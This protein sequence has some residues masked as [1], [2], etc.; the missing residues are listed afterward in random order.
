MPED[1]PVQGARPP[2]AGSSHRWGVAVSLRGQAAW[3]GR[4]DR[5]RAAVAADLSLL[6]R[7]T[8]AAGDEVSGKLRCPGT[9][10]R[11]HTSHSDPPVDL[12][13]CLNGCPPWWLQDLDLALPF[14][15]E[16]GYERDNPLMEQMR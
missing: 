2:R 1:Q 11:T 6:W 9:C 14:N 13:A 3:F 5:Q 10:C 4:L 7:R 8:M 12:T 16:A 15:I